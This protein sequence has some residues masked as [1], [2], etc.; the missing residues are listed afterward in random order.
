MTNDALPPESLGRAPGRDRMQTRRV[1]VIGAGQTSYAVVDQPVGNGRAIAQLLARE[2]ASIVAVDRDA[3][4]ATETVELIRAEGGTARA[5]VADVSEPESIEAMIAGARDTLGS[6]DGLVYNVGI[7]GSADF[8][9]TT[10]EAWDHVLDVNLRGAMLTVRAA[11]PIME[12]GS[13]IVFISSIGAL[14]GLGRMIAYD[15]SKAALSS[16]VRATAIARKDD[17]VR[18]NIVMPGLIDTGIG[19]DANRSVP[20]RESVP[21]PLG[22]RGTAWEVAY[23][24]LFLL[25]AE[26]SYITGQTLVVDGGKTTL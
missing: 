19:R 14:R 13:S 21:V 8:E 22:R 18:A 16:L 26:S 15:A 12:K 9:N 10:A 24:V 2:G 25:G 6:L 1:A 4:S 7:P 20:G 11:L 3:A 23:A 5:W 17:Q